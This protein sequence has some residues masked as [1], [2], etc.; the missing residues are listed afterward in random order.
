[1]SVPTRTRE[2]K[3]GGLS[4]LTSSIALERRRGMADIIG[5]CEECLLW[6]RPVG[7]FYS[8]RWVMH[9]PMGIDPRL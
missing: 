1:M 2:G 4:G 5:V 3:H 6:P 7:R 8:L 9:S